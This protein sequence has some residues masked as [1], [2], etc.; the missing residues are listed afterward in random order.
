MENMLY[1]LLKGPKVTSSTN[2]WNQDKNRKRESRSS[3][4]II[5][6][7]S[8]LLALDPQSPYG[9][10]SEGGKVLFLEGKM[11]RAES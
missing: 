6:M 11:A 3:K 10:S 7:S 1:V 2:M 8:H 9:M 5:F 4:D